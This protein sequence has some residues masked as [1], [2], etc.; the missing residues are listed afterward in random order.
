MAWL[1][2]V[3]GF[4][5]LWIWVFHREDK[6]PE[7]IG[8]VLVAFVIGN[9]AFGISWL[10]ERFVAWH[11]TVFKED[12]LFAHALLA[13]L[14]IGPVEEG[15]K[16]LLTW[17]LLFPSR[18]FD[19]PMDGILYS[20]VVATGFAFGENL[21][22][23]EGK[24]VQGLLRGFC[25]TVAHILFAGYWGAALGWAK[26][27]PMSAKRSL[28]LWASL[29]ASIVAHGLYDFIVFSCDRNFSV[30]LA[31]SLL[32]TLLVGSFVFLRWQMKIFQRQQ[33]FSTLS[34]EERKGD[35]PV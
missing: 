6:H 16:F 5:L 13:F 20:A 31:R 17:R 35:E 9:I 29:G 2:P 25:G 21:L 14:V 11:W 24:L 18:F 1:F 10:L 34:A 23:S 30:A 4:A 22:L 19:E 12:T 33:V 3:V 28:V 8:M 7:P 15:S 27:M 32:G 26:T